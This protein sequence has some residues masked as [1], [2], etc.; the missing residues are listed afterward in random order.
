VKHL[1]GAPLKGRPLA[2]INIRAFWGSKDKET[3]FFR[4]DNKKFFWKK[5]FERLGKTRKPY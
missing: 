1:S 4:D 2:V 5:V 3:T